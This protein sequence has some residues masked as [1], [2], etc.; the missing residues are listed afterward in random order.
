MKQRVTPPFAA[1]I[2]WQS[3]NVIVQ[4]VLQ[5]SF[6]SLLA[7]IL[8]PA[9]FGVMAIA[10][11]VV[12]FVEIFAQVG[13]G[14]ALI[15]RLDLEERHIRSAFSFSLILGIVFF[16]AMYFSAPAIGAFFEESLL[17][18]VL[19]WI[20]LSFVRWDSKNYS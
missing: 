12:G 20:A 11:V 14:P 6:I 7:R 9:D 15:Q 18:D 8:A 3:V 1:S 5:L 13:I 10:L 16:V 17:T 2:R 19:R 4:V